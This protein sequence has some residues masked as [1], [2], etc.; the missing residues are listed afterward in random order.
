MHFYE[1]NLNSSLEFELS[2]EIIYVNCQFFS[3]DLAK[4]KEKTDKEEVCLEMAFPKD[5]PSSPPFIRVVY[6]RFRQVSTITF[7]HLKR[8]PNLSLTLVYW[9]YYYRWIYMCLRPDEVRM[10]S[11]K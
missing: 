4:Y 2:L 5:Y 10:E 6:P 7:I 3:K 11:R 8:P 1:N 9:P